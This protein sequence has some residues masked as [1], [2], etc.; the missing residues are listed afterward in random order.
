[1]FSSTMTSC[2]M[3]T[4]NVSLCSM[5]SFSDPVSNVILNQHQTSFPTVYDMT[6][7]REKKISVH[8]EIM[9]RDH[10][11]SQKNWPWKYFHFNEN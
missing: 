2:H 11:T 5:A 1:M 6:I 9:S 4:E 10:V 7:F 8:Y 3:T